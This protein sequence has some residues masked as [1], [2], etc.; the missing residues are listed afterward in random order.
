MKGDP[1][2][3]I[4]LMAGPIAVGKSTAARR[5]AEDVGG[6]VVSVRRALVDVLGLTPAADRATLQR[7]GADLDQRTRGKWLVD[8]LVERVDTGTGPIVVDSLRTVRQTEPIL[9]YAPRSVLVY[10]DAHT[11]TRRLRY[12]AAAASDPVKRSVPFDDAMNHP[13]EQRVGDLRALAHLVVDTD[14]L[15]ADEVANLIG[16]LLTKRRP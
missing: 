9:L 12:A 8:Y 1:A 3:D 10:L 5:F 15:A 4:V 11:T 16:D 2:A 13:T 7:E 6:E 14:D